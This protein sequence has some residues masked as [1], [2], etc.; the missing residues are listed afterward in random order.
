M[1]EKS[2]LVFNSRPSVIGLRADMSVTCGVGVIF[3]SWYLKSML[4]DL[5]CCDMTFCMA[6]EWSLLIGLHTPRDAKD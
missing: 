1:V 2:M 5:S 3:I 4:F 6:L